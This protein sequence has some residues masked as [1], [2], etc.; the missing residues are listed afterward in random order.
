[1]AACLCWYLIA[2]WSKPVFDQNDHGELHTCEPEWRK[3]CALLCAWFQT[4]CWRSAT[5][6]SGDAT[7]WLWSMDAKLV[8]HIVK[9]NRPSPPARY[10]TTA[11]SGVISVRVYQI[12]Q[13]AAWQRQQRPAVC[14]YIVIPWRSPGYNGQGMSASGKMLPEGFGLPQYQG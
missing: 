5:F 3:L 7:P 8:H 4:R 9:L 10:R 11:V 1:M 12:A 13:Q 2:T 6:M 14:T